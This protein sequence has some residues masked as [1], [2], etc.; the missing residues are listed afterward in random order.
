LSTNTFDYIIR[1]QGIA[2]SLLAWFLLQSGKKVLVVDPVRKNT[3]SKIAAGLIHPVTGRRIVKSWNADLFIPFARKTYLEIEDKLGER[4]FEDYP[5]LELFNDAGHRNDWAGRSAD[6]GMSDY[7]KEECGPGQLPKGIIASHGGRWVVNGGWVDT[8]RFTDALRRYLM[9]S[10]SFEEGLLEY[11]QVHF[12]EDNIQWK[13]YTAGAIIDCSGVDA[14]RHPLFS[15]LPFNPCKGEILQINTHGLPK[16]MVIHG[17]M[18]IIP[19]G[20][21]EY[22]TGATYDFNRIDEESTEEGRNKIIAALGKMIDVPYTISSQFASI[23]PSTKDRRPIIGK[24]KENNKIYIFNGL[25]SKGVMMGPWMALQLRE[26]LIKGEEPEQT[27]NPYRE[28]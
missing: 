12:H 8:R 15:D 18:K 14:I 27:L 1:G 16:D 2:G 5:V 11:D 23:R 24:H 17:A 19:L 25:G 4:F 13:E 7:V 3:C 26:F 21:L 9:K 10:G 20:G 6:E 28:F 22:L